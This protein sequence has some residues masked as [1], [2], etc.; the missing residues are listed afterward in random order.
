MLNALLGILVGRF[1]NLALLL[2]SLLFVPQYYRGFYV[3]GGNLRWIRWLFLRTG[4]VFETLLSTFACMMSTIWPISGLWKVPIS[5]PFNYFSV[6]PQTPCVF[7][8]SKY[9]NS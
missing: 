2:E 4:Y 7:K 8:I 1:H 6:I 5:Q 9:L 3:R